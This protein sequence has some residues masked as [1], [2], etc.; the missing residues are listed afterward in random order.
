MI[1]PFVAHARSLLWANDLGRGGA[2]GPPLAIARPMKLRILVAMVLCLA[3]AV[4][5]VGCKTH[6]EYVT[7]AASVDDYGGDMLD[8]WLP[9][10]AAMDDRGRAPVVV[11]RRSTSV[12]W[13]TVGDVS[14]KTLEVI[15]ICAWYS[16]EIAVHCCTCW[17]K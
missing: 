13:D 15:G 16:L 8:V 11:K 5:V 14:L 1:P 2:I 4:G 17:A 10:V 6:T 12:D 9:K 7:V 3:S